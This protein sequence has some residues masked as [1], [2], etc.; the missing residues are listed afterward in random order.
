MHVAARLAAVASLLLLSCVEGETDKVSYEIGETGILRLTNTSHV[1]MAIGGCNP[2]FIEQREPGRWVPAPLTIAACAFG[3]RPDGSHSL[4][5]RYQL[6][7]PQQTI[8]IPFPTRFIEA[9][10]ALIRVTQRISVG[11]E[12][13]RNSDGP[14]AC[15]GVHYFVTDPI[16]IFGPDGRVGGV[17]FSRGKDL[18]RPPALLKF[19]LRGGGLRGF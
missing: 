19:P 11:C 12:P 5:G 8:E 6:L 1:R 10:P 15:R 2:Q 7:L 18:G 9:E 16:P 3:T 13:L 14:L 4:D 17:F